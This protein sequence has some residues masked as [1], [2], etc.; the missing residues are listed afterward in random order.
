MVCANFIVEKTDN[1]QKGCVR[2]VVWRAIFKSDD[3]RALQLKLSC[4][5]ICVDLKVQQQPNVYIPFRATK[6][7][8]E[9]YVA[10]VLDT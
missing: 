2:S 10:I 8:P 9:S 4:S 6:N 3:W 5:G 1:N 7:K